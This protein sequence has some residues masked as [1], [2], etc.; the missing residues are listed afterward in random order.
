[1]QLITLRLDRVFD[2]VSDRTRQGNH[3]VFSFESDGHRH[4][5][6]KLPGHHALRDGML[7]TAM[8]ARENDWESL[9]GWRDHE[10]GEVI[11]KLA[12]GEM[13]AIPCALILTLAAAVMRR[14]TCSIPRPA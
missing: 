2:V 5:S 9:Q 4:F 10:T 3:T 7:V 1:M 14:P 11:F 8:L 13:V 6:V 12:S